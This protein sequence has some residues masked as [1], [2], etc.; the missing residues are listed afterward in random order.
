MKE[1]PPV[2]D[3]TQPV[4]YYEPVSNGDTKPGEGKNIYHQPWGQEA[5]ISVHNRAKPTDLAYATSEEIKVLIEKMEKD[6]QSIIDGS[7]QHYSDPDP[8]YYR[9]MSTFSF[10][11]DKVYSPLAM[12]D[13]DGTNKKE[14]ETE[15]VASENCGTDK[16]GS[17]DS[18]VEA[19][20][21]LDSD[22]ESPK[23][24]PEANMGPYYDGYE[25]PRASQA[26]ESVRNSVRSD[27]LPNYVYQPD[28]VVFEDNLSDLDVPDEHAPPV[29]EAMEKQLDKLTD[30]CDK[31]VTENNVT[32]G[33]Y[34]EPSGSLDNLTRG[35]T[36]QLDDTENKSDHPY[37]PV[38]D[39]IKEQQTKL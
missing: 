9:H 39:E 11:P 3:D 19:D 32:L 26:S 31:T 38:Y 6:R 28:A 8:K 33:A 34:R 5:G 25:S 35:T 2:E 36:S 30:T 7:E 37:S 17:E 12:D 15:S 29:S 10:K 27:N 13:T 16:H 21:G 20:R 23:F 22:T 1:C 14:S 24:E 18:K 4:N